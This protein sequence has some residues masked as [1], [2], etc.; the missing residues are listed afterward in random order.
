MN[1]LEFNWTDE[2]VI[3]LCL[4]DAEKDSNGIPINPDVFYRV[5]KHK[6]SGMLAIIAT[7]KNS[8]HEF[9]NDVLKT[10]NKFN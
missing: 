10:Q 2:P 3:G 8:R 6:V 1:E 5:G 7:E 9:V 4:M